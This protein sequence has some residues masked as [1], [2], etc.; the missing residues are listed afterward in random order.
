M[1]VKCQGEHTLESEI[2]ASKTLA[3]VAK[4]VANFPTTVLGQGTDRKD[5]RESAKAEGRRK[6]AAFCE[7]RSCDEGKRCT[8][9]DVTYSNDPLHEG[10]GAL[11][12]TVILRIT[13]IKCVCG[14][15]H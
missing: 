15:P 8:W 1:P 5:A 13:K 11:G 10:D 14:K 7:Q 6:A 2:L 3:E 9:S 4:R 12:G